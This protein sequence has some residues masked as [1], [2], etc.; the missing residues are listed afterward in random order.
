[1]LIALNKYEWALTDD[2]DVLL[3][4]HAVHLSEDLVND[5]VGSTAS[6]RHRA[7]ARLRD[8]VQLVEEQH[9]RR[10]GTGLKHDKSCSK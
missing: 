7:T 8:R 1:M 9:T 4:A 2:E 6:V 5:A 3:G 10:R